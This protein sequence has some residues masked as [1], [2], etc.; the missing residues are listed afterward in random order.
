[1]KILQMA[2]CTGDSMRV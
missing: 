1:M 2:A